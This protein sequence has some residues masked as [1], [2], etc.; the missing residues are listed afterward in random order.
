MPR[1]RATQAG[2]LN[3]ALDAALAHNDLR[4]ALGAAAD[5]PAVDLRR[6]ARLLFLMSEEK[7]PLYQRAAARWLSRY[8]AE[9][10][11]LTPA[12]LADAAGT[13]AELEHGDVDAAERLLG[14][15]SDPRR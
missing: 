4:L 12:M 5:L 11:E 14:Q 7:S 13:L 1:R 6:A 10:P 2:E 9:T 3:R 8:A 15:L